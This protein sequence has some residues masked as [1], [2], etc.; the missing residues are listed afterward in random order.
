MTHLECPS[1]HNQDTHFCRFCLI[2]LEHNGFE[3]AHTHQQH[4]EKVFNLCQPMKLHDSNREAA[5]LS[6]DGNHQRSLEQLSASSSRVTLRPAS[7]QQDLTHY[8]S[9]CVVIGLYLSSLLITICLISPGSSHVAES[10]PNA[11]YWAIAALLC[12]ASIGCFIAL[13]P[14]PTLWQF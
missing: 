10:T 8:T 13:L 14:L 2:P 4:F 1:V 5:F 9:V 6:H 12:T 11:I 3:E 7:Q